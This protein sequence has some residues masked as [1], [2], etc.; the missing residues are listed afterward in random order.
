MA[1]QPM[2]EP[3]FGV[4]FSTGTITSKPP[5]APAGAEDSTFNAFDDDDP[6]AP[7]GQP[8]AQAAPT[9][10]DAPPEMIAKHRYDSLNERYGE[11]Q[12]QV[13]DLLAMV[14]RLSE[15]TRPPA[16]PPPPATPPTEQE[17]AH[18]RIRQQLFSVMP[19]LKEFLDLREKL[20]QLREAADMVPQIQ[21]ETQ[22]RWSNVA[23]RSLAGLT[24][25]LAKQI[26][27]EKLSPRL[28]QTAA[29]D[30]FDWVASDPSLVTRYEME[31]PKLLT[32]FVAAFDRDV[33]S[34]GRTRATTQQRLEQTRR[35]PTAGRTSPPPAQ[36]PPK[37]D[38]GDEDA[39]FKAGWDYIQN[40]RKAETP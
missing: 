31:D 29:R 26:G 20:P 6:A 25:A 4:D 23:D 14:K 35:L 12:R 13:R 27:V 8:P 10:P 32:E 34:P 22:R 1:E 5:A 40:A 3:D 38:S 11:T 19:E 30:F 24:D 7:A 15:A 36:A 28:S 39:V 33:L 18:A 16:A 21:S 2:A 17:A 37:P 9:T